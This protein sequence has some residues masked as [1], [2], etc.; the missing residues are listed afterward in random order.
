MGSRNPKD[1]RRQI[2]LTLYD[3]YFAAP[4]EMLDPEDLMRSGEIAHEELV[5]NAHYLRDRGLVELM[6][7]YNTTSFA[8]IRITADGID[9]VENQYAFNTRFPADMAD[10][11]ETLNEL[12][13]LVERLIAEIDLSPIEGEVRAAL[14][15]DV[16]YLREEFARP[17]HRWRRTVIDTV[18]GWIADPFAKPNEDLPS[19]V[20]VQTLLREEPPSR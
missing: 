9:L 15:R 16:Q 17:V 12:P 4:L 20:R 6:I 7:G 2:L 19:L 1:I 8:A 10:V 5:P 3:R 13:I 18:L 14:I 11:T